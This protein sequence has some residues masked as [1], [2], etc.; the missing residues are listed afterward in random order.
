MKEKKTNEW[1]KKEV[2]RICGEEVEGFVDMMKR[3]KF[4]FFGHL[5]RGHG[6][7]KAIVK[8]GVEGR[9]GRGRPQGDWAG[10]LKDWTGQW[11][12]ELSRMANDRMR[13][14]A[15]VKKWVHQRPRPRT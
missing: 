14:R 11:M 6:I 9:R 1:I 15:N 4:G 13:W 2:V 10:N 12:V 5:V 7:L 8:G 3:R